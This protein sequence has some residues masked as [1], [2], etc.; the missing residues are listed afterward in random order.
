[1]GDD[2]DLLGLVNG[3]VVS[4]F[5]NADWVVSDGQNYHQSPRHLHGSSVGSVIVNKSFIRG[6]A[7][8]LL[9]E[10]DHQEPRV[11]IGKSGSNEVS[12]QVGEQEE[13]SIPPGESCARSLPEREVTVL[14][15]D[16]NSD[17]KSKEVPLSVKPRLKVANYGRV[18]VFGKEGY[19]VVPL[20]PGDQGYL[21]DILSHQNISLEGETSRTENGQLAVIKR[22]ET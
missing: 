10:K 22:G 18:E 11:N 3:S 14:D 2:N 8:G 5:E 9:L 20:N 12:V 21:T 13:T 4:E 19:S 6:H 1:L 7:R 17:S 15:D 16:G